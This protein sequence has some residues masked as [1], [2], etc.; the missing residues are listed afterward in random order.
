MVYE[1]S[2]KELWFY[3]ISQKLKIDHEHV[4]EVRVHYDWS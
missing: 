4:T 3:D 1:I 2:S